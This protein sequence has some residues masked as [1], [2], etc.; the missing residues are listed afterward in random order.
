MFAFY[1]NYP[2]VT[3]SLLRQ[4]ENEPEDPLAEILVDIGL[5]LPEDLRPLSDTESEPDTPMI[6]QVIYYTK[7]IDYSIMKSSH[8]SHAVIKILGLFN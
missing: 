7:F 3:Y 6:S 8:K 2:K 1:R 5:A 4:G